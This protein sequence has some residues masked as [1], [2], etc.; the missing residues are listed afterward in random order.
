MKIAILTS[1]ALVSVIL[2]NVG[3]HFKRDVAMNVKDLPEHG[4]ILV[5]SADPSFSELTANLYQE[6]DNS[7]EALK[8]FS[9]LLK[10][11]GNKTVIAYQLKWELTQPDGRILTNTQGFTNLEKL[12]TINDT[13]SPELTDVTVD[14]SSGNVIKPGSVLFCSP[15][16]TL[17]IDQAPAGGRSNLIIISMPQKTETVNEI[18]QVPQENPERKLSK[19]ATQLSQL[20]SI[21]VSL[22]GALFDDGTFVGPDSTKFFSWIMSKLN[23]KLDLLQEVRSLKRDKSE[24]Q[25]VEYLRTIANKPKLNINN[26]STPDD[27]YNFYKKRFAQ[28]MVRVHS[29]VGFEA[30]ERE[31]SVL[32]KPPVKPRK[33]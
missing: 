2:F 33:L 5:T 6:S 20:S 10:N 15:A 29:A 28:Q 18:G 24:S 23:A 17:D 31:I 32:T 13:E 14:S 7:M 26:K 22:D 12:R 1:F 30:I 4:L 25:A 16:G 11:M 19:F 8:P 27:I 3:A 21:T 9:V